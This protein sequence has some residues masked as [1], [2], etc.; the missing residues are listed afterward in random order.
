MFIRKHI[1]KQLGVGK[2]QMTEIAKAL[3]EDAK[4]LILDEP[5][6]ALAEAEIEQLMEILRA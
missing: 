6:S 5:T 3:S 4:I 2:M 1:V